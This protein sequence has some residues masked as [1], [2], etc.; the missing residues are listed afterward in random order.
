MKIIAVIPA[1]FASTTISGKTISGY[2][3][4]VDDSACVYAGEKSSRIFIRNCGH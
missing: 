3:G 4:Y 2:S 1:R